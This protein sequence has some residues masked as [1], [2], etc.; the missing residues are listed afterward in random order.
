VYHFRIRSERIEKIKKK[1][2]QKDCNGQFVKKGHSGMRYMYA[3]L[4][5]L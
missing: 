3:V 4:S 2:V 1:L 5:N